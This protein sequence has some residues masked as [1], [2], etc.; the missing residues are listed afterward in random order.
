MGHADHQR[1]RELFDDRH[2]LVFRGQELTI[3]QQVAAVSL[4]GPVIDEM[5]D[6]TYASFVSNVDPEAFIGDSDKILYHA[7]YTF[8]PMPFM[9]LSLYAV[10]ASED[11]PPT[12]YV[13]LEGGYRRLP[14]AL[15]EPSQLHADDGHGR[16]RRTG[17][18]AGERAHE[19]RGTGRRGVEPGAISHL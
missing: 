19:I 5:E 17:L 6:G 15:A 1:L 3:E 11:A 16:F 2:L 18:H 9:G 7:D 14:G 12:R 8:T 4:L 13:S 10:E